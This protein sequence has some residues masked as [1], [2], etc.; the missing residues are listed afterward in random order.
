MAL[1]KHEKSVLEGLLH[2]AVVSRDG[3]KCRKCGSLTR[4]SAAHIYS[5]GKH[6]KMRYI[7]E[8]VITLCYRCHIHWAHK[9]P[10]EFTEWIQSELGEAEYQ[11]L[12][13]RANYVDKSIL[14]YNLIKVFLEAKIKEYENTI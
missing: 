1:S 10:I 2:N 11:R 7:L 4:L 9:E 12:R 5:K 6:R 13:L 14:D 3:G 8:N